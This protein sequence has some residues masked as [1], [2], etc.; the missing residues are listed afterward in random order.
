MNESIKINE[1]FHPLWYGKTRYYVVTGGRGSGKSFTV[2]TFLN[3]LTFEQGHIILFTRWTMISAYLSIIPEYL[4]K[5]VLLNATPH[6]EVTNTEIKN[7]RTGS[8]IIFR[9]IKT[10][11]GNQTANLKSLVGVTTWVLDESEEMPDEDTFDKI[12]LSVRK[13]GV[14]NRVIIILNPCHTSHWIYKRFFERPKIKDCFNGVVGNVTY[15]HTDYRD[16]LDNL[17]QSFLDRIEEIRVNNPIKYQHQILGGWLR[18]VDGSLWK[19]KLI[20]KWRVYEL[21]EMARIV[22]A[23]DPA[24]TSNKKSDETGIVVAGLG[25]NNRAYILED[26]S[27]KMTPNDWAKTAIVAYRKYKADRIIGETNNGGD[28]IETVLRNLDPALPYKSVT[29]SRGKVTRAEPIVALYEK[30]VVSHNGYLSELEAQMVTWTKD[31]DW[32]PDRID[33]LVWAVTELL[34][35]YVDD[36]YWG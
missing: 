31:S 28:L 33:A 21:P 30:G 14:D 8:S 35:G 26:L 22:I 34:I 11:Q 6:F 5:I 2:S 4:E 3:L 19:Q 16:N 1:K 25:V 12:D 7:K 10:S 23:I 18:D 17:D 29:A 27:G 13:K 36:N 9:G 20:D 15:I 32:S 24:V